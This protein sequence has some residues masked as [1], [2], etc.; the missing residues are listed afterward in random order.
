MNSCLFAVFLAF[1][2]FETLSSSW[3]IDEQST[4]INACQTDRFAKRSQSWNV[5]YLRGRGAFRSNKRIPPRW[6]KL[7]TFLKTDGEHPT[8]AR[9]IPPP[10]PRGARTRVR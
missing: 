2:V 4:V 5:S 7:D 9:K 10:P 6:G 1:I 8:V 3:E